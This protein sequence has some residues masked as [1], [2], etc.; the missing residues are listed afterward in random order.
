MSDNLLPPTQPAGTSG[1]PPAA[2][3]GVSAPAI[4]VPP[5]RTEQEA[6]D[7]TTESRKNLVNEWAER[8]RAARDFWQPT[9]ERMRDDMRFAA[10]Q[11]WGGQDD[12]N[13][14][15]LK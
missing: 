15:G 5:A 9:F 14:F 11:Q 4:N 13:Q 7:D 1:T 10:G 12:K 8:I 2:T 3:G 6:F